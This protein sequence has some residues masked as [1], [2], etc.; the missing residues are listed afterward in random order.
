[1]SEESMQ[2]CACIHVKYE[3]EEVEPGLMRE[4][5]RCEACKTEFTRA[6]RLARLTAENEALRANCAMLRDAL[7]GTARHLRFLSDDEMEVQAY[8]V[9]KEILGQDN[10]GQTL[11]K[12]LKALER[13]R[14]AGEEL[15]RH[16]GG[17][18]EH[19][20]RTGGSGSG[21]PACLRQWHWQK[22]FRK[23]TEALAACEK[24]SRNKSP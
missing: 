20:D 21:C 1:M 4:R 13:V 17:H 23:A 5:W 14:E 15:C 22:E 24:F 18:S 3:P 9:A 6:V 8:D 19:W 10:P 2:A 16:L 12:H 7:G 11:L